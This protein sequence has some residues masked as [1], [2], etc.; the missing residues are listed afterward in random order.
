M[1][2]TRSILLAATAALVVAAPAVAGPGSS[3]HPSPGAQNDSV[4][5]VCNDNDDTI[6]LDGPTLIWPPNHKL[7]DVA[8]TMTDADGGEV[9]FGTTSTHDEYLE[10][11]T[12]MNGSGNTSEDYADIDGASG[13]GEATGTLQVRAERSGQGDGRT[14]TVDVS[15]TAGGDECSATF[16]LV[17]PHDMRP[18]NRVKPDNG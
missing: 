10:D 3:P 17:V 15:G 5:V 11:G 16:S 6:S 14:Y 9:V 7:V 18:S 12:E 4:T 1:R 8:I 13:S 2:T